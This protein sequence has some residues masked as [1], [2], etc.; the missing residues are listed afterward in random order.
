MTRAELI[1]EISQKTGLRKED[2]NMVLEAFMKITKEQVSRGESIH[3]RGFGS[4]HPK[5]RKAKIGQIISKRQPIKIPSHYI[6][7]FSPSS[8][9]KKAVK[10]SKILLEKAKQQENKA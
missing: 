3:L 2:V 1:S 7:A 8:N 10:N 9:F 5:L 4:F 6:P